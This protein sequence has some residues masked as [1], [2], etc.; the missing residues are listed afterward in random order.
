MIN[1]KLNK[2]SNLWKSLSKDEKKKLIQKELLSDPLTSSFEI[3]TLDD[4]GKI[5]LK[6][7]Q[8]IPSN[9][10]GVIL[11]DLEERL[12]KKIDLALTIWLEPVGDKSKLRNLRGITMKSI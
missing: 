6:I 9:I 3:Y 1:H 5:V 11:L 2:T 4:E 8:T 7:N 10:R 12:K